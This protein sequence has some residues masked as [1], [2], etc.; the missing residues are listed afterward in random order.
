[1]HPPRLVAVATLSSVLL[2]TACSD[3]D[4]GS[5]QDAPA[6]DSTAATGSVSADSTDAGSATD[7]AVDQS[8][9]VDDDVV[10]AEPEG[11]GVVSLEEAEGLAQELLTRAA[12]STQHD[13]GEAEQHIVNAFRGPTREA[14]L[15]ADRLEP[16][17]GKP[18]ERD[19]QQEPVQP[20]VLAISRDDGL[21]PDLILVQTAPEG[22]LPELHLLSGPESGGGFRITWS[23]PMLPGT[24]VGTFDR[25][26]VGSPVLRKGGGD[27][28][29]PPER[30]LNALADYVDYPPSDAT[31]V[32]TNGYAPQVRKNADAQ[33]DEV[34]QQATLREQNSLTAD[35]VHTLSMEDGSGITFAVL[36]RETVFDVRDGSRLIP[37]ATFTTFVDDESLTDSATIDTVVFVAMRLP[38]DEGPA[39]L[40]AAREQVVDASG[41]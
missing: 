10:T 28:G 24:K 8:G 38:A 20:N 14:A 32:R 29:V 41:S 12:R 13:A 2:L 5:A 21:S 30:A 31:D 16:V 17:T 36:D 15:A 34:A 1:M 23:A 11:Q 39:E 18:Q 22:E 33:A 40:I 37:P 19:L 27:F 7:D 4:D 25:R 9:G 3:S 35:S 26:S 6:G